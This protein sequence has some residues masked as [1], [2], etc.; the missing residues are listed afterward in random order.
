VR[1]KRAVQ[2]RCAIG[3]RK[4]I[5]S[6][7]RLGTIAALVRALHGGATEGGE[8]AADAEEEE[9]HAGASACSFRVRVVHQPVHCACTHHLHTKH[10]STS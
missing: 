5:A 6:I 8:Q 2:P 9:R 3:V 10:A 7:A 1:A 4:A